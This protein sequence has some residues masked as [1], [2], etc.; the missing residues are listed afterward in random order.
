[1]H[2]FQYGKRNFHLRITWTQHNPKI[3]EHNYSNSKNSNNNNNNNNNNDNIDN[4]KKIK[5]DVDRLYLPRT[6]GGRGLIQLELSFKSTTIC[7]DK[8]GAYELTTFARR[9]RWTA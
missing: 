6:E 8:Q 7:L 1:M 3:L 5:S 9:R 4:I 2:K